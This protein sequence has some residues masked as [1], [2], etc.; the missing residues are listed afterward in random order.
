MLSGVERS[1]LHSLCRNRG[2][3]SIIKK[4]QKEIN[5]EN[6]RQRMKKTRIYKRKGEKERRRRRRRRI[7]VFELVVGESH[8]VK[9]WPVHHPRQLGSTGIVRWNY[10]Q[11]APVIKCS[12]SHASKRIWRA[13]E[14]GGRQ[15]ERK[16]MKYHS[17]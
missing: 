7:E 2:E 5:E 1:T 10:H 11:R 17:M 4:K 3:F 15:R 8:S 12:A 14:E 16:R 9:G 6:H 13:V